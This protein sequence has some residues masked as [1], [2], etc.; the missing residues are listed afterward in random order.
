[1]YVVR[2][3]SGSRKDDNTDLGERPGEDCSETDRELA[4]EEGVGVSAS[5]CLSRVSCVLASLEPEPL[6]EFRVVKLS[7]SMGE[8]IA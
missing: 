2:V 8:A 3:W 7:K 6:M 5:S 1:M 4:Y